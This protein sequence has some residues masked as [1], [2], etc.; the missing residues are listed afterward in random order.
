M[1]AYDKE[2]DEI[3]IENIS[4]KVDKKLT[5]K[6]VSPNG[7]KTVSV[8]IYNHS[9]NS[10]NTKKNYKI[11]TNENTNDNTI[12]Q[13]DT[14]Y[15]EYIVNGEKMSR[16]TY[17]KMDKSKI[18]DLS[19]TKTNSSINSSSTTNDNKTGW[20]YFENHTYYYEIKDQNP[21]FYNRYGDKVSN[22]IA[23]RLVLK[24]K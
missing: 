20:V 19:I 2:K 17:E 7:S 9:D 21:Y 8:S 5:Y 11:T 23:I 15:E 14:S 1:I 6:T 10:V 16:E 22:D 24:L 12:N 13:S 3:F 18:N 4:L